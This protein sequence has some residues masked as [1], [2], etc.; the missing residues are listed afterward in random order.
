MRHRTSCDCNLL[1]QISRGFIASSTDRGAAFDG[2]SGFIDDRSTDVDM[3][4]VPLAQVRDLLGPASITTTESYDNE[5]L[6]NLQAA[7]ALLERGETFDP[8]PGNPRHRRIFQLSDK[9]WA[10]EEPEGARI[11]P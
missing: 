6:E 11:E 10:G 1:H 2:L 9:T 3:R 7:A 5:K 8:G 4:S